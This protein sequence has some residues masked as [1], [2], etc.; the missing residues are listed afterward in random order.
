MSEKAKRL[1]PLQDTLRELFL[2]SGNLCAFPNCDHLMMNHDGEFIGQLCHIEAAEEGGERFNPAMNNEQRRAASN[3]M[4][5]CYKHHVVTN[6]VKKYPVS[7]LQN[8]KREHE[9]RFS[10]PDRAIADTLIDWTTTNEPRVA[11]SLNRLFRVLE[12]DIGES[13]QAEY[14]ES[15]NEYIGKLELVPD[16]VRT[17]LAKVAMRMGRVSGTNVVED[18]MNSTEILISDLKSAFKISDSVIRKRIEQ[19]EAYGLGGYTEMHSHLG[20]RH[21]FS[22][23][24][25]RGGWP[26]WP[27]LVAFCDA[28]DTAIAIFS[29]ELDF[30][31][32]D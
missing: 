1:K 3:L 25:L 21:A 22:I 10:A 24:Y 2:K 6:N 26:L 19:F 13:E 20:D 18:S 8:M 17:F 27:D 11:S 9:A 12:L 14:V 29:E 32:L 31:V 28:T 16:D 7:K 30:S 23:S 5:M 15:L 4:L